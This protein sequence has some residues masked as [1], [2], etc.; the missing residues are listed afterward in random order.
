MKCRKGAE[1]E[2][3]EREEKRE[4]GREWGIYEVEA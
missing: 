1:G 2:K 4:R 3:K